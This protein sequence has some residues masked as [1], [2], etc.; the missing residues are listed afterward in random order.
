M[1]IQHTFRVYVNYVH[2]LFNGNLSA[3]GV[4][5]NAFTELFNLKA[6]EFT[7]HHNLS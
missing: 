1:F 2:S 4:I 3:W 6:T 7:Q 5:D